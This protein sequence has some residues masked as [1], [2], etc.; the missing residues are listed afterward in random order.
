[1]RVTVP[2]AAQVN[3]I[4]AEFGL[5]LSRAD[6]AACR[7]LMAGCAAACDAVDKMPDVLP[8]VTCPRTPGIRPEDGERPLNARY[9]ASVA[10]RAEVGPLAGETVAR[11]GN[12]MLTGVLM[13]NGSATL[14]GHVPDVVATVVTRP[15]DAAATVLGK[16]QCDCFRLS[17]G[18]HTG[19]QGAVRNPHKAGCSAGGLL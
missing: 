17:G 2:T 10:K 4:A 6:V 19:A 11:R 8:T 15:P 16:V 12:V 14:E 13:M 5:Y 7:G 18:S 1:M 3:S 9:V